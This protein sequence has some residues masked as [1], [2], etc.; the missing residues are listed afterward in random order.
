MHP[1]FAELTPTWFNR[2]Y[3]YTG[4]IGEFRYRFSS[5]QQ[6]RIIHA[7]VY[8]QLC[9]ELAH[10]VQERDFSWDDDG[11]SQLRSWLQQSYEAY[12]ARP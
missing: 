12:A 6:T 3:V 10:D 8:S 4:S 9:Y 2:A 1:Q 11:V 5:D 7:S